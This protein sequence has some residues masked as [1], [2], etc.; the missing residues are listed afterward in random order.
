[1][2][3]GLVN[4]FMPTLNPLFD[5]VLQ[6]LLAREPIIAPRMRLPVVQ[7]IV[8]LIKT[9]TVKDYVAAV[10]GRIRG[11]GRTRCSPNAI[12]RA[13]I[14][15]RWWRKGCVLLDQRSPPI[16]SGG[17]QDSLEPRTV[18]SI[19]VALHELATNAARVDA[20]RLVDRTGIARYGAGRLTIQG[21][22]NAREVM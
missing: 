13:L 19:A 3:A 2:L 15:L 16:T 14:L 5:K 9:D 1:M 21:L 8:H 7:S 18:R 12:G 17:P 6:N 4:Q 10:R 20:T 11:R 22:L